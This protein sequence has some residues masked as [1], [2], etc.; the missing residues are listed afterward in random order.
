[1]DLALS[2]QLRNV[3][4]VKDRCSL[5][6]Q[7]RDRQIVTQMLIS[8]SGKFYRYFLYKDIINNDYKPTQCLDGLGINSL[9]D[10]NPR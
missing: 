4:C 5:C 3:V 6:I 9:V 10:E 7:G 1:M 2:V 8:N